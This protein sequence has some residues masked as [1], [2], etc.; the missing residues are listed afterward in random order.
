MIYLVAYQTQ[1]AVQLFPLLL[2]IY[3]GQQTERG[4]IPVGMD[5]RGYIDPR[6]PRGYMV[7]EACSDRYPRQTYGYV[8]SIVQT[9]HYPFL[10]KNKR[11]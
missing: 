11:T 8:M 5:T 2:L 9:L 3:F 7:Q 6:T 10:S 1:P 4:Y